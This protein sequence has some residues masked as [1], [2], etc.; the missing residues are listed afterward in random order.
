MKPSLW[1]SATGL[2]T[3]LCSLD[4]NEGKLWLPCWAVHPWQVIDGRRRPCSHKEVVYLRPVSLLILASLTARLN[5][6]CHTNT[7]TQKYTHVYINTHL[8]KNPL[9]SVS[10]CKWATCERW[11]G[12][13]PEIMINSQTVTG[14][15]LAECLHIRSS[16][17]WR[18]VTLVVDLG[19]NTCL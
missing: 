3:I 1:P 16:T 17:P 6:K 11:C 13:I 15:D 12:S 4:T 18:Y 5:P 10:L 14:A 9:Y 8:C 7:H 19:G 2:S